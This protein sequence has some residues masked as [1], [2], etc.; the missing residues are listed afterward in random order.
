MY[1]A[2]FDQLLAKGVQEQNFILFGESAFFI[3]RYSEK[4][5]SI[6]DA[7]KLVFYHDEYD[8]TQAKA[9]LSQ[10]SLFGG[11]NLLVIKTEKKIPKK[12]LET[13]FELCNKG[14][15]RFIYG[16]YGSDT[17]NTLDSGETN[18]KYDTKN[19]P[20]LISH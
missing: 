1:K 4:L 16:Y 11:T 7:N 13:L 17:N 14:D 19:L 8:F 15:N 20:P 9:H 6:E 3:D 12:E 2:Q 18:L 5:S 10:A